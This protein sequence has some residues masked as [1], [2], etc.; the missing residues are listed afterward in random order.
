MR[1]THRREL[2]R[3]ARRRQRDVLCDVMLSAF[4]RNCGICARRNSAATKWRSG[5]ASQAKFCAER[6]S[7]RSGNIR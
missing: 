6:T 3:I 7:E 4:L 2:L 5:N 1:K